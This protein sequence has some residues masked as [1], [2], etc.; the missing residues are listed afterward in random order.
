MAFHIYLCTEQGKDRFLPSHD[1]LLFFF[2]RQKGGGS[3]RIPGM[4]KRRGLA[5][6]WR[7]RFGVGNDRLIDLRRF[8]TTYLMD[9]L[10]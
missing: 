2:L 4:T 9:K 3:G 8:V 10:I 1:L 6:A 5:D 7:R